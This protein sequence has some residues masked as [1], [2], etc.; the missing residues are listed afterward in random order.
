[1]GPT[2]LLLSVTIVIPHKSVPG[3][4]N[5]DPGTLHGISSK[6]E[7]CLPLVCLPLAFWHLALGR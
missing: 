3:E 5:H 1:M 7:V 2:T 4:L 6:S